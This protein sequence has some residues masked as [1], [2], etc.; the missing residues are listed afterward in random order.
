MKQRVPS[1][2][3]NKRI[4]QNQM[5]SNKF[6]QILKE[7]SELKEPV[8]KNERGSFT[9]I[10]SYNNETTMLLNRNYDQSFDPYSQGGV[11]KKRRFFL[12]SSA[13]DIKACSKCLITASSFHDIPTETRLLQRLGSKSGI[14]DKTMVSN[15]ETLHQSDIY[16]VVVSNVT[17]LEKQVITNGQVSLVSRHPTHYCPTE[18]PGLGE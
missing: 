2:E 3:L 14:K 7:A 12:K 17:K 6:I 16:K 4:I 15:G 5:N 13:F 8:G 11:N 18:P 1:I 9:V 10:D